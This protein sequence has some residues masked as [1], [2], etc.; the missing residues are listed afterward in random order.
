MAKKQ[1]RYK[2]K[3]LEE[4]Q[5]MSQEDLLELYP[6]RIRRT[7]KRGL[8]PKQKRL[9]SKLKQSTGKQESKPVRTHLRDMPVLPEMVGAQVSIYNGKE[10]SPPIEVK[11]EMI[12][13]Y[14]GEFMLSRKPVKH[15]APGVGATRSSLFVP[16]R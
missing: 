10:F 1:F 15:S 8:N 7:L 16:I 13:H 6:S 4:L 11:P 5:N 2:G 14:L 3:T 9:L 12:G